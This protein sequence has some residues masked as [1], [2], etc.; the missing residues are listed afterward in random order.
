MSLNFSENGIAYRLRRASVADAEFVLELR[1]TDPGRTKYLNSI[2]TDLEA[3][4]K[5]I[6]DASTDS[7][8]LYFVIENKFS[9]KPEGLIGIYNFEGST[10]EWG[11]WITRRDSLCAIES[12]YLLANYAFNTLGLESIYSKTLQENMVVVSFHDSIGALRMTEEVQLASHDGEDKPAIRHKITREIFF[13]SI[14]EKLLTKAIALA[15]RTFRSEFGFL[16]FHHVGIA[17]NDI[18][19]EGTFFSY[20]GYKFESESFIDE[21]QGIRGIFM[22]APGQPRIELLENL[23][24]SS[25]LD[26]WLRARA[27]AYHFAYEVEDIAKA[28]ASFKHAGAKVLQ[29]PKKSTYFGTMI[30]FLTL[31]NM[32]IVEL[33]ERVNK[34]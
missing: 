17:T 22:S 30:S 15:S 14:S 10:A 29:P 8:N 5:W 18:K 33:I 16:T 19:T 4:R 31:P 21:N 24:G 23:P 7:G 25:T 32:F 26:Y 13:K 27:K 20:L 3:Q 28:I 1:T 11:R 6:Q 2:S 9:N 34:N 12:V